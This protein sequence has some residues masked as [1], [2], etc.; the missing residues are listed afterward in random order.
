MFQIFQYFFSVMQEDHSFFIIVDAHVGRIVIID[1]LNE[2]PQ[3]CQF[4]KYRRI[5]MDVV[6]LTCTYFKYNTYDK[7]I[8]Y[9]WIYFCFLC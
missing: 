5:I 9:A 3:D 4:P 8:M 6:R 7:P 1:N 2:A